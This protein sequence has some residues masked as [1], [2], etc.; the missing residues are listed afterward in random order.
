L[1]GEAPE[2]NKKRHKRQI[3]EGLSLTKGNSAMVRLF[4]K[5]NTMSNKFVSVI[6]DAASLMMILLIILTAFQ[7]IMRYIFNRPIYGVDEFIVVLLVWYASLGFAVVTWNNEHAKIEV[8]LRKCPRFLQVIV[9]VGTYLI[10][11]AFG[12]VL[13]N[14]GIQLFRIQVRT[15][16]VGGLPF[17]RAYYYGLPM[18]VLGGLLCLIVVLRLCT[19]AVLRDD[20]LM[21]ESAEHL[22]GEGGVSVD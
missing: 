7:V 3:K 15:S 8:I 12:C 17:N 6:H 1:T 5:L 9:Y 20:R 14:G 19:Y 18:I 13:V 16:N 2:N 11:F 21:T 22:D 4:Q 10:A